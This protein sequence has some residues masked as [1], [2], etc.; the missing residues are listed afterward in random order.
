MGEPQQSQELHKAGLKATAARIRIL[1]LL[2]R[3]PADHLSAEDVYRRL[4]E[5][6][7]EIGLATVYRV[8]S[9]FETA[10]LVTRH[11]FEE[12]RSVFERTSDDHHDHMVDIDTGQVIE[13][14]DDEIE[15]LQ[16]AIADK[17]GYEIVSHN[18]VLFVRAKKKS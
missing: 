2:E 9:Q 16:H 5:A 15:R 13:F 18:M 4:L 17:H 8:L 10:G 6:G 14:V 11:N 1:Q 12:G 7:Q 3:N